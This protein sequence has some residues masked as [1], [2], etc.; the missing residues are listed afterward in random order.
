MKWEEARDQAKCRAWAELELRPTGRVINKEQYDYVLYYGQNALIS[1]RYIKSFPEAIGKYL[2]L[3]NWLVS[4][5]SFYFYFSDEPD[6]YDKSE[7]SYG[8][9]GKIEFD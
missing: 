1:T 9:L 4:K 3:G 7:F 2:R 5:G 6:P 8:A